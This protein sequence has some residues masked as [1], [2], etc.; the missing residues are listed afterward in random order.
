M[1]VADGTG[2]IG[3]IKWL[4]AEPDG[5]SNPISRGIFA[6]VNLGAQPKPC[7]GEEQGLRCS[8]V[9]T[10]RNVPVSGLVPIPANAIAQNTS[11]SST[12]ISRG[13]TPVRIAVRPRPY[14]ALSKNF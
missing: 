11:Y 2:P 3:R 12:F 5:R 9:G 13:G 4:G 7:L 8:R 6:P 14:T 1:V 10:H